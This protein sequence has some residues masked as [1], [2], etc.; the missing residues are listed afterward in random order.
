MVEL[1]RIID[2]IHVHT[3]GPNNVQIS[4]HFLPQWFLAEL[5][6][7][8][9]FQICPPPRLPSLCTYMR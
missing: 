5:I 3:T 1:L 4:F 7:F 6:S 9:D 8:C 2:E